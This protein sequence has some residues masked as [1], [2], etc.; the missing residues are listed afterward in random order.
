MKVNAQLFKPPHLR[1]DIPGNAL[2]PKTKGMK[3]TIRCERFSASVITPRM[4]GGEA[5]ALI[6]T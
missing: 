3:V 4:D 2:R 1:V 6:G 5:A